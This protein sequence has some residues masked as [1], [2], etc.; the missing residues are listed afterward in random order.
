MLHSLL[1]KIIMLACI[2]LNSFSA[3]TPINKAELRQSRVLN[4]ASEYI[5]K[6]VNSKSTIGLVYKPMEGV[7]NMEEKRKFFDSFR[8]PSNLRKGATIVREKKIEPPQETEKKLQNPNNIN[9]RIPIMDKDF[10]V[11]ST[12][13]ENNI[14]VQ[15]PSYAMQNMQN[16]QN[17][18][19]ADIGQN[20]V[21]NTIQNN[22]NLPQNSLM[23]GSQINAVTNKTLPLNTS[24][25]LLNSQ[26]NINNSMQQKENKMLNSSIL[27]TSTNCLLDDNLNNLFTYVNI[28]QTILDA[29][30]IKITK[31]IKKEQDFIDMLSNL[32]ALNKLEIL[33]MDNNKIQTL[34]LENFMRYSKLRRNLRHISWQNN[35][36]NYKIFESLN[37]KNFV[38]LLVLNLSGNLKI[39]SHILDNLKYIRE[40]Y[41][42]NCALDDSFFETEIDSLN[43]E[44]LELSNNYISYR[45]LEKLAILI[46]KN[47]ITKIS[48]VDVSHNNITSVEK[49]WKILDEYCYKMN[50]KNP[51]TLFN[52]T[53]LNLCHNPIF[54]LENIRNYVKF[55]QVCKLKINIRLDSYTTNILT[56]NCYTL[57][58]Q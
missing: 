34:W 19:K 7:K 23:Q 20:N 11:N 26:V 31:I 4:M 3:T 12:N 43:L 8:A 52:L 56:N 35:M 57:I 21:Q 14:D 22:Y 39:G 48:H 36:F 41:L 32:N 46:A 15:E 54:D 53:F 24:N 17:Y 28:K 16:M 1:K 9:L 37:N 27:I 58:P 6:R 51:L 25:N 13:V 30:N 2:S 42:N 50:L 29:N 33:N 44:K 49:F 40:L 45:G 38:N 55:F 10:T 18:S 47:I 5:N